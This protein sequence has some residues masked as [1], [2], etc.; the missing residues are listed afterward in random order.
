MLRILK[1]ITS[2]I[3]HGD[4]QEQVRGFPNQNFADVHRGI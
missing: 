1:Y 4:Q 2:P 3:T